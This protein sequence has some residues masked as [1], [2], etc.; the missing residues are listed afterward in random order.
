MK[1][2]C[3]AVYEYLSGIAEIQD[4][5]QGRVYPILLPQDKPLPAIVYS[6]V[7]ANYDSALQGDTGFVKQTIQ[8]VCHDTTYKR[9][10]ELSRMLKR[11]FQDFHGN[12]CGLFIQAVFIKSDYEYNA[13]TALKFDMGEYMSSLEFEFFFNEK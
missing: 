4:R 12:M 11:A 5:V 8:F 2:I 9:T 1:D 7:I 13:N 3:Q 10:R 6:P